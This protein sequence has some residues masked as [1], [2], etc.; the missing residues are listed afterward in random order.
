MIK[1]VGV[2]FPER[3]LNELDRIRKDVPRSKYIQRLV[4]KN[5]SPGERQG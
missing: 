5:L 3:L 2:A 4:E 1:T